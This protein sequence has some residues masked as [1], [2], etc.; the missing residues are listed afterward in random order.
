MYLSRYRDIVSGTYIFFFQCVFIV[1]VSD[2]A[3]NCHVGVSLKDRFISILFCKNST[4]SK[5]VITVSFYALLH[6]Y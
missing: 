4:S 2:W 5:C 1:Q 3:K 6:I